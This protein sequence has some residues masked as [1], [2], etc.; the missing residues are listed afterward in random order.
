MHR[1]TLL[2]GSALLALTPALPAAAQ[3]G[4]TAS[5]ERIERL[6]RELRAVQRR[7]FPGSEGGLFQPQV[8]PGETTTTATTPATTPVADL[9]ARV[10]AIEAQLAR[11]TGEIEQTS[12]RQREMEAAIGRLRAELSGRIDALTP[13]AA[14][15]A[16]AEGA[17]TPAPA[18]TTP[19]AVT[20]T[21]RPT[22]TPAPAPAQR[23]ATPAPAPAPAASTP[24]ATS[25][26]AAP[27]NA[28]RRARVAAIE[29]PATGNAAEDAYIYGFRLWSADLFPEAQIQLQKVIDDHPNHRRASY[30]GN[31][32]GRAYLDNNQPALAVRA[33]YDNYRA[34]PRGERAAESVYYMGMALIRLNRAADACRTFDE[35]TRNYGSTATDALRAQVATART[36]ARC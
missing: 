20:T 10:D 35:F 4:D 36:Q 8:T 2:L 3:S 7:V 33:F 31:L 5:A 22:P 34:R 21:V 19:A 13:G 24:A 16:G 18:A 17:A 11:L 30:A 25:A 1:T 23:P 9:T 6:E 12:F 28:A 29:V 15:T 14:A 27:A 26:A 32:L